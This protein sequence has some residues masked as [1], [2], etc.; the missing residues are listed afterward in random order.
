MQK[1]DVEIYT[2]EQFDADADLIAAWA[3]ERRV[4][5]IYGVPRG[6]WILAVKLSHLLNNLPIVLCRDEITRDTLIVDDIIQG[7]NTMQG[8]L[9][10]VGDTVSVAVLYYNEDS[11]RKPDF[12]AHRRTK[13]VRFPWETPETSDY[14]NTP[15]P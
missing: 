9:S 6:G 8:I 13:W 7:G 12:Y 4:K 14:N 1:A 10:S 3:R 15:I 2:W 5:N 11:S